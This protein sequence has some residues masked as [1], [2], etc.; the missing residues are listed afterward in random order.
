M[1]VFSKDSKGDPKDW[2]DDKF[3]WRRRELDLVNKSREKK[4]MVPVVY[5]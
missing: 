3:I 2:D 5:R 4:E 1:T